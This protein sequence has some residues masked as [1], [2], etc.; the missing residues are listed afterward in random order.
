MT[1]LKVTGSST[2]I[3]TQNLSDF[4]ILCSLDHKTPLISSSQAC[5][6]RKQMQGK[7][8]LKLNAGLQ[9]L[10]TVLCSNCE[11]CLIILRTEHLRTALCP[12]K[13]PHSIPVSHCSDSTSDKNIL[14]SSDSMFVEEE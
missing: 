4:P 12:Y 10:K 9:H 2:G 5:L 13:C 1:C 7:K 3:I 14:A 6:N 8:N 11:G